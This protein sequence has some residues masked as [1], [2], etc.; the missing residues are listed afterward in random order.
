MKTFFKVLAIVVIT[1][2]VLALAL[3]AYVMIKNPF[4][5][6][7][8]V[9]SSISSQELTEEV[10]QENIEKNKTYDHPYL[11]EEQEQQIIDAGID[12]EKIP[13][14]ITPE[15]EQC[16]IDKLGQ[17]RINEISGGSQPTTL[18][19]IKLLPCANK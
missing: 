13:T 11:N 19:I 17:D 4:G 14:E 12:L 1:I 10:K 2:V 9:K 8:L 7:D 3:F 5:V 6:A 16:G 18:E 15:Q